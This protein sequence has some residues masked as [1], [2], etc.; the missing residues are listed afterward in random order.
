M[1]TTPS[2]EEI[3]AGLHARLIHH[4]PNQYRARVAVVGCGSVGSNM[5]T[6][7]AR[8][9]IQDL[10]LVDPDPVA[11]ENLSRTTYVATDIGDPKPAAL[12][13]HLRSIAPYITVDAHAVDVTELDPEI[14]AAVDLTVLAADHPAAEAW[15]VHHLYAAGVPHVSAKLYAKA[16]AGEI[17][18][19]VPD[20]GTACIRCATGAAND[21][22]RGGSVNYGTGRLDGEPALG[23]DIVAVC[24]RATKVALAILARKSGNPLADWITPLLDQRRTLHLGSSVDGWGIFEQIAHPPLDGPFASVWVQTSPTEDCGVC[25]TK[26]VPPGPPLHS[27]VVPENVHAIIDDLAAGDARTDESD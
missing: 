10:L 14:L 21:T 8:S 23:P 4:L 3:H 2:E 19:V 22:A 15:L 12:A 18:Y 6:L 26:P 11:P 1:G 7:L 27:L 20:R 24:A 17:V 25:G 5:A 13:R 16:D 9:G